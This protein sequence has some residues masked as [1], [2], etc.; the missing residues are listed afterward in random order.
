LLL[1]QEPGDNADE[2]PEEPVKGLGA[3]MEQVSPPCIGFP[4]FRGKCSAA[5]AN[6]SS[7]PVQSFRAPE[8]TAG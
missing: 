4:S 2:E 8:K 5:R 1:P 6:I 3:E 7:K